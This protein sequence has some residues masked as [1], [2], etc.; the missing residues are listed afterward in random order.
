MERLLDNLVTLQNII[1]RQPFGLMT[2]IDG[3]ISPTTLDPIHVTIPKANRDYLRRLSECVKVV[4]VIS[5]R[6]SNEVRRLVDGTK[7]LCIGHYGMERW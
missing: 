5:G 6:S 4:A 2:D 7:I 1:H 3:T